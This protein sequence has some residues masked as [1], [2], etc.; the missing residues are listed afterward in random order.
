DGDLSQPNTFVPLEDEISKTKVSLLQQ[1]F[2]TQAD[3]HWFTDDT[4]LAL[5]RL[6]G[7]ECASRYAEAF[8]GRKIIL[9][10]GPRTAA[11][12][13]LIPDRAATANGHKLPLPGQTLRVQNQ[14][15]RSRAR[16]SLAAR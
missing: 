11:P 14:K 3:K 4:F 7:I 8:F 15:A 6:R 13:T 16:I 5:M 1:Y 10:P 9:A 12:S 2:R